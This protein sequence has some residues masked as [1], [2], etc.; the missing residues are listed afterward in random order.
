MIQ[1]TLASVFS[2]A[3][4]PQKI[5]IIVLIGAI[6]LTV[7]AAWLAL[8]SIRRTSFWSRLI[9]GLSFAGP[10]LGLLVGAMNSFHMGQ[11]IQRAPFQPTAK[12]LAPGILEVSTLIGLGALVG[13]IAAL[14]YTSLGFIAARKG[15]F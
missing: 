11:T 14:A 4:I 9:S 7:I 1:R 2:N 8:K 10:A 6:P 15:T 12:Q 13:L 3:A 5:V